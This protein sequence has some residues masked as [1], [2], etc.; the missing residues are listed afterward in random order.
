MCFI[1]VLPTLIKQQS[2]AAHSKTQKYSALIKF[3]NLF[4]NK[5][6]YLWIS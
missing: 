5:F 6:E 3:K 4:M 1:K 2:H